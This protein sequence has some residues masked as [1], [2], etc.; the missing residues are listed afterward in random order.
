M[1][2]NNP[3]EKDFPLKDHPAYFF[4]KI[5]FGNVDINW[6]KISTHERWGQ[7]QYVE[8]LFCP[9]TTMCLQF[10]KKHISYI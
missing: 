10:V 2:K 6:N 9:S 5:N 3:L 8:Q 7:S 1:M 4:M